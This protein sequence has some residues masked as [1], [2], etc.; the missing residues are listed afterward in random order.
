MLHDLTRAARILRRSPQFYSLVIVLLGIGIGAN[1]AIFG[2][3]D[4]LLLRPLLVREPDRLVI[5]N[6]Q[7]IK[8]SIDDSFSYP[9]YCDLKSS[10]DRFEA[11]VGFDS[12]AANIEEGGRSERVIRELVT[13]EYFKALGL[14]PHV[15]RLISPADDSSPGAHPV[16]VLTHAYWQSRFGSDSSVV[17]RTLRVNG[18]P[19]TIIG[20]APRGFH[21]LRPGQMASVIVP[22]AMQGEVSPAFKALNRRSTSWMK[23]FGRLRPQTVAANA[24]AQASTVFQNLI[25]ND[26]R[27]A[28]LPKDVLT[29][30]LG[31]RIALTEGRRGYAPF[32]ENAARPLTVLFMGAGLLLL[33]LCA[34]L[35]GLVL[36][37]GQAR[38]KEMAMRVALGASRFRL[39]RDLLTEGLILGVAGGMLGLFLAAPIE[40]MLLSHVV[41]SRSLILASPLTVDI[42]MALFAF[43]LSFSAVVAFSLAPAWRATRIDP[44]DGLRGAVSQSP[45]HERSLLFLPRFLDARSAAVITQ[46]ALATLLLLVAALFVQT[47]RNLRQQNLGFRTQNVTMFSLEP[48][49]QGYKGERALLLYEKILDRLISS[50]G[51]DVASVAL[52]DVLSGHTRKSSIDVPGGAQS[53]VPQTERNVVVNPVSPG[54]FATM[55][56]GIKVGRDFGSSDKLAAPLVAVVNDS[57]AKRFLNGNALGRSFHWS[58]GGA[59]NNVEIIGVVGNVKQ[60]SVRGEVTPLVYVPMAQDPVADATI[61]VRSRLGSPAIAGLVRSAVRGV[62]TALAVFDFR[63]AEQQLDRALMQERLIA[64]SATAFGAASLLLAILGLYGITS[65]SVARRTREFGIRLALGAPRSELLR[66]ILSHSLVMVVIGALLGAASAGAVGR[67]A[68]SLMFGIKPNDPLSMAAVVALV[69]FTAIVSTYA[70][71]RRAALTDPAIALRHE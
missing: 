48:S 17:G 35:A 8:G 14:G 19:L 7:S 31:E 67:I 63:T 41:P 60:Q 23:V 65:H 36:A 51:V 57:F 9:V 69:C 22:I 18:Y 13:G 6:K 25:R 59:G 45:G 16:A 29:E 38:A 2:L 10:L 58:G 70:P 55:G 28:D 40:Q 46:V 43:S 56:I 62:D 26:L 39:V 21:G 1:T 66:M 4:M 5:L 15:G 71:A 24:E 32:G 52:T 3:F 42:R 12:E 33:A 27:G 61:H 54:Y 44:M 34:N 20:V 47:T 49:S 11:L 50:P 68:K 64:S 37:R 30:I 53:E